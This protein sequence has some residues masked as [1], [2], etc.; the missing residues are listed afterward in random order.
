M[1][2]DLKDIANR[3]EIEFSDLA[4]KKLVV[5]SMN[6][7]FQFLSSIR[8][9]DGSLL[10]DSKGRTT[11]HLIGLFSRMT[12]L[13]KLGIDLAFVFDGKKPDLKK[14]EVERRAE[15]KKQA[16]AEY[17]IAK[18]RE[19]VEAMKKY[20]SRTSALTKEMIEESKE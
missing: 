11:S 1:G 17:E 3:E 4:G 5:D 12:R 7:I 8:Q 15:L 9:M 14:K 10:T 13:K 2:T 19:D 6:V 20:A 18:E 16:Q